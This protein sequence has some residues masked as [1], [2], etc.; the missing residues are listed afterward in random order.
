MMPA[1]VMGLFPFR[2]YDGAFPDLD[3]AI[4]R[5]KTDRHGRIDKLQVSPLKPVVVDVVGDL[6]E[7]DPFRL[8]DPVCLC[9]E[10]RVQVCEVVA[11]FRW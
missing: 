2:V 6:G 4:A 8:Q 7:Q 1:C 9:D 5:A 10:R 3:N 11:V